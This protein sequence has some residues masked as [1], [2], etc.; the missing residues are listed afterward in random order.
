[1]QFSY[2]TDGSSAWF[3]IWDQ[4]YAWIVYKDYK[5][6]FAELLSEDKS[7]TAHY[8]NVQK[9]P[10]EMYKIKNELCPNYARLI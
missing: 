2:R 7:I 10:I 5:S 8:K 1:M 3:F 9:L 6:F 4:H